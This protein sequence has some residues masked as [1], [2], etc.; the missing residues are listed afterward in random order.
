MDDF[1]IHHVTVES[2]L[3]A[4]VGEGAWGVV[5]VYADRFVSLSLS[6][7]SACARAFVCLPVLLCLTRFSLSRTAGISRGS[8]TRIES[9]LSVFPP[10]VR[11]GTGAVRAR[12]TL[13]THITSWLLAMVLFFCV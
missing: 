13:V 1:G 5:Q 6:P 4:A 10:P 7:D 11:A 9:W 2:P 8:M 3:E 12:A